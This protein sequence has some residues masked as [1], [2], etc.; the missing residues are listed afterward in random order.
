M[1]ILAAAAL[2]PC[3]AFAQESPPPAGPPGTSFHL[4]LA[5]APVLGLTKDYQ[6]LGLGLDLQLET[7]HWKY[8]AS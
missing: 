8:S 3:A 4:G 1:R 6:G 7:T 5:V 2:L